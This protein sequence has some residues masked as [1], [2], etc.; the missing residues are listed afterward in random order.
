MNCAEYQELLVVYL[1][2]LLA[3]AEKQA[4][5]EHLNVCETC[6][7]ELRELQTLQQRLARNGAAVADTRLEDEVMNR[8]IREQ[9]ARLKAAR[10]AGAGLRL[11]RLLMKSTM[12]KL[13]VAAVVMLAVVA[14]LSLWTG[15]NRGVLLADVLAKVEQVQAFTYRMTMHMTGPMQNTAL[16]DVNYEATMLIT[17][18][19]GMKMDIAMTDPNT[20]R[21]TAQQIYV[22][23]AEKKIVMLMPHEKK[24]MR[25]ELDASMF[26]K[27][28]EQSHDPRTM[29]KRI[30]AARYEDL[31]KSV[32]DGVEV[33]G[34]RT[35]DPAYA[36][37]VMGDVDV[38]LWV[39][40]KTWLPVRMDMNLKVSEQIQM[41]GT[42][43][44][45]QWEVPVPA[46]EFASMI[47]ADYTP[48]PGDGI[49]MP[50]LTEET[51]VAG[52]KLWTSFLDKYPESLNIVTLMQ[53]MQE[54]QNS[55][56][57]AALQFREEVKQIQDDEAK[58]QKIVE[59]MMPLQ[60]LGGFYATL[61]QEQK[62]PAYYGKIVT[63][64]DA[65]QVLLRWKTGDNEYRVLFGDLHAETVT[66]E[67]LAE[68]EA[69]LP[70]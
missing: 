5:E 28:K 63:P 61:V 3:G 19:Y 36:G 14:A 46:N 57:P 6:R 64:G 20:G 17:S 32:I 15:T 18:E 45:F 53:G 44:D 31:G 34:F 47:P 42:L 38:T 43:H 70:R 8:I 25:M 35:T 39:D 30:L 24:Y 50:A 26:E 29:I 10:P 56:T 67:R 51:A 68:L 58:A 21:T 41:Q 66:A 48:G 60:T 9:S 23:P 59:F 7:T 27:V 49:K 1:E 37:G 40:T 22:L 65:G 13:A 52:L 16:Q 11:R 54:V 33:E 55:E 69:A 12:A 4:V 62:E 2:G